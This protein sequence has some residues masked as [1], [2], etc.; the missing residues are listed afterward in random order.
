MFEAATRG[1]DRDGCRHGAA[2]ARERR[3]RWEEEEERGGGAAR[4]AFHAKSRQASAHLPDK[5]VTGCR[6]SGVTGCR[7]SDVTGCRD[8]DVAGRR[9]TDV[10]G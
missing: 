6:D 2:V 5:A 1:R 7:D 3:G 4:P 10:A 9:D 8:T